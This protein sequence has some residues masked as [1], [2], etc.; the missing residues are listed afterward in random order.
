M[1]TAAPLAPLDR[2][3]PV[4]PFVSV[5]NDVSAWMPIPMPFGSC[6]DWIVPLLRINAAP[7]A[8]VTTPGCVPAPLIVKL[9]AA[10]FVSESPALSVKKLVVPVCTLEL[11]NAVCPR[12]SHDTPA[13][14]TPATEANN[15]ARCD[16]KIV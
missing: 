4:V 16:E 13:M 9:P 14:A 5:P 12:A 3:R 10:L 15:A 1:L 2:I 11:V 7:F 6:C 8:P